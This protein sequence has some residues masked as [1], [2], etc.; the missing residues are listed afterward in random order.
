MVC[1]NKCHVIMDKDI[2]EMFEED[3]SRGGGCTFDGGGLSIRHML[4]KEAE[5]CLDILRLCVEL[6][7][8]S[9]LEDCSGS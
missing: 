4:P 3:A 9:E 7:L 6:G 8:D 2:A 5:E 1:E